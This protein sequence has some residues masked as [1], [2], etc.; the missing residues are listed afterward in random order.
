MTRLAF[1]ALFLLAA[2]C[3]GDSKAAAGGPGG[4]G[5]PP[6]ATPV[7]VV[8]A[9]RDTVVD[10]IVAT[11][12]LEAEQQVS[13]R[14]DVEGRVTQLL[15][16][17]GARVAAGTPLLKIDDAELVAQVER[18]RADRDLAV[19]ALERTRALL[20]DR[21]AAP[22]DLERAEAQARSARASLDLLEVRLARTTVRAP[23]AGVI[24]ERLVSLGDYVT[25]Q[26]ALLT[27][28]TVSPIRAA[29]TV[30]ERYASELKPGQEVAFQVAALSGRTFTGRVDFVDPVV[31]L[32]ARTITVKAVASNA[33]GALA[34]GM[35]LEA[36]LATAV[37]TDA[38]VIPEEAV[39]PTSGASYVWVVIDG[40]ATRREVELGVRTPGFVEVRRGVEADEQVVVGGV[41]RMVEG[42]SVAPTVVTRAPQGAREE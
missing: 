15:F 33:D 20:A 13:L 7:E 41:D 19:Q 16:R 9:F 1:G 23:F 27:L 12:A 2:A 3:G 17:E 39:A 25:P 6:R 31:A 14:P 10:A 40:K 28:Q 26:T 42:M 5:G 32:P 22:A 30:P 29:F 37:R 34:P 8:A 4:A 24:G 36:R 11:G 18:A 35:F 21:A 38:I